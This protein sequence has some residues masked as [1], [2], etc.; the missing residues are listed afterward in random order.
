LNE[1]S[2]A[3]KPTVETAHLAFI[4]HTYF[5]VLNVP[6]LSGRAFQ[7]A[8]LTPDSRVVIVDQ[9]FVDQVLHGR[10]AVGR[11]IRL[12]KRFLPDGTPDNSRPWYEIVGV[13]KE[14]GMG[15]PTEKG[16]AA[17][18]YRPSVAGDQGPTNMVV[19][20]RGDPM[21]LV[22]KVRSLATEVDQTL[23]LSTFQRID[24]V[25]SGILWFTKLWINATVMLTAIALLLSLAGIY[26]VMSFTVSRRTREIGIRVALGAHPREVV[27]SIFRRPVL[28]VVI[29]VA[30]GAILAGTFYVLFT[31]CQDGVCQE[32]NPVS[33]AGIVMLWVYA[34]IILAVCLLACVVPT[35]RALA[36]EPMVALR[37]E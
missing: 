32:G 4:D 15:A 35:R 2:R 7:M 23:R 19:H 21:M 28:Q 37:T 25:T 29:G 22:P 20:V 26:A 17:G 36:V 6:I 10:N 9:G 12:G 8:D 27:A 34:L 18:V 14:L 16:R 24:Q 5:D 11:R 31:T 33:L 13:V 3:L 30:V 1:S